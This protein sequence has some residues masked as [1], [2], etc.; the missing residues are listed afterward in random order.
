MAGGD[1]DGQWELLLH[2]GEGWR[3]TVG[4]LDMGISPAA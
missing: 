3:A 1:G 4:Q 2:S